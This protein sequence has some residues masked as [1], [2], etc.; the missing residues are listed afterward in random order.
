MKHAD[1]DEKVKIQLS[2]TEN[3]LQFVI[4]NCIFHFL[5]GTYTTIK[6]MLIHK[7]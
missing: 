1:T 2:Q 3:F 5:Q 6:G 4:D 7:F